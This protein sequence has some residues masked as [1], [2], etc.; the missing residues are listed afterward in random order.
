LAIAASICEDLSLFVTEAP[1]TEA[2]NLTLS[3]VVDICTNPA[4][5]S[6]LGALPDGE[7]DAEFDG[8]L[9]CFVETA[10]GIA[11]V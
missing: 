4:M 1:G 7:P 2:G 11:G 3:A 8:E 6:K 10:A 9:V 5:S